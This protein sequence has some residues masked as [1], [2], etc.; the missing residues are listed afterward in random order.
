MTKKSDAKKTKAELLSEV[1]RKLVTKPDT[2][3]IVESGV[4]KRS[5]AGLSPEMP[6]ELGKQIAHLAGK[7]NV[8]VEWTVQPLD[9]REVA[10]CACVCSYVCSCYALPESHAEVVLDPMVIGRRVLEGDNL[11]LGALF[12]K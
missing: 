5:S 3:N 12:D 10:A 11:D 7:H 9:R 8:V 1:E 6:T 4:D 2:N